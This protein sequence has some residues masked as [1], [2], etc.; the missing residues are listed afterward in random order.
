[1]T[2]ANI[3]AGIYKG[4]A[5][6]GSEQYGVTKGG[7]DQIVLDLDIQVSDGEVW[8][9]STFLVFSDAAATYSIDRLRACGWTGDDVTNLAGIDRNEVDVEIAY[10]MYDGKDRLRVQIMTGGGRV[11]IQ[12]KLDD[13]K[14][15]AFGARFKNLARQ[16]PVIASGG[17]DAGT[18]F[19]HGGGGAEGQKSTGTGGKKDLF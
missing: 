11:T 14:K 19:P 13:S 15:R 5:I 6:A 7:H 3:A 18:S 17:E 10:E 9:L 12:N 2:M 4:R 8:R 16:K 1:M